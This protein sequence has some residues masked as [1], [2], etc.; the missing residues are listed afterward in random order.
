MDLRLLSG[1]LFLTLPLSAQI[2]L[3]PPVE[4]TQ[5]TPEQQ[6]KDL[7]QEKQR[8]QQE[9]DYVRGRVT[10]A[11]ELLTEKLQRRT[12]APRAIDAGRTAVAQPTP[13][14]ARRPAR[15]MQ[16]D[17]VKGLQPD[18]LLTVNG[19]FV[20]RGML[21]VLLQHQGDKVP[22]EMRH[23]MAMFELIRIEG[24]AAEFTDGEMEEGVQA[25][26]TQLEQGK[27]VAELAK[28]HGTLPGA[29][30]DGRIE[31]GRN[32]R[33]GLRLEQV[34]FAT[35]PGTTTRPFRHHDGA[36]VLH[37]DSLEKGATPELDKVVGH[38]ILVP[39]TKDKDALQKAQ[40]QVLGAQID[41]AVRDQ[42]VLEML[43]YAFRDQADVPKA[44]GRAGAGNLDVL[45]KTLE[46]LRVELENA[47]NST[48]EIDKGRVEMLELRYQRM[49]QEVDNARKALEGKA[50][51]KLESAPSKDELPKE[52]PPQ[53]LPPEE[54][55]DGRS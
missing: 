37:V 33:F 11:K 41:I 31:I 20:T 16:E 3:T 9:I 7:E 32:Q 34:A 38:A 4:K 49:K 43:P 30:E 24:T 27:T 40:Q 42:S 39:Y 21:D 5:T 19:A 12:L 48:S 28:T 15:L 55:K 2:S 17:E 8:L 46:E 50:G 51:A 1:L 26:L 23:Q 6:L 47:R 22:A 54:P 25:V 44:D 18:V 14:V 45:T 52:G 53:Q 36:V 29:G 13:P 35:A 10:N